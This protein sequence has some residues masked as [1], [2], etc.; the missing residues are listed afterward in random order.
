MKNELEKKYFNLITDLKILAMQEKNE[1]EAKKYIVLYKQLQ[2]IREENHL[3]LIG[4]ESKEK[5]RYNDILNF[6]NENYN[7]ET[8][9]EGI[10]KIS[11]LLL[12]GGKEYEKE[13]R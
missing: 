9:I 3:G 8:G 12:Q 2:K 5:R 6:V 13:D 1:K 7:E 4:E 11:G 10:K